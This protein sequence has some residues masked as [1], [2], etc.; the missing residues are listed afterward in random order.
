M[1]EIAGNDIRVSVLGCWAHSAAGPTTS[2]LLNTDSSTIV[3]DVGCDPIGNMRRLNIDPT[4]VNVVYISHLHS[5]HVS[6]LANF[7][8]TRQ[9]IGRAASGTL[10]P[11]AVVAHS[12]IIGGAREL[13][14]IQYP[15]RTFAV[16]WTPVEVGEPHAIGEDVSINVFANTHTVPCFG[17]FV[18][19]VGGRSVAFT[20]DTAPTPG[21]AEILNECDLLIGECFGTASE[22]GPNIHDRGHSTAED[23]AALVGEVG[24]RYL[25][26]FHFGEKY[27]DT[28]SRGKLLSTCAGTTGTTVIDPVG[29]GSVVL[30]GNR[31]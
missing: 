18:G 22:C 7:I 31:T 17:S 2:F 21:H 9:L 4:A 14:A 24:P 20:S 3:L 6:G 30:G 19:F 10:A 1:A 11:L 5:D 28:A 25:I 12:S 27:A 23:L 15:E 8:F 29:Q 26:P 16:D 13:V